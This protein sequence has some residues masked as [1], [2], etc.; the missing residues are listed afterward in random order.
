MRPSNIVPLIDELEKEKDKLLK[1]YEEKTEIIDK[2]IYSIL[3]KEI[4][5]T[6]QEFFEDIV[7][8]NIEIYN[9]ST[10]F[11][12]PENYAYTIKDDNEKIILNEDEK[13][14]LSFEFKIIEME[15]IYTQKDEEA[16]IKYLEIASQYV[17]KD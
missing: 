8:E 6:A 3:G 10:F 16:Q 17:S 9:S 14:D 15:D 1:E 7:N 11:V 2:K 5:V 12:K 4:K 13:V